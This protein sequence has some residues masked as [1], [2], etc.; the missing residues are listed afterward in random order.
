MSLVITVLCLGAGAVLYFSSTVPALHEHVW[1]QGIE[2][3]R[4]RLRDELARRLADLRTRDAALA[5]DPQTLLLAI[6]EAKLTPADLFGETVPGAPTS[7]AWTVT[8]R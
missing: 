7:A 2:A 3:D 8:T 5:W 6:D 4:T 1:L